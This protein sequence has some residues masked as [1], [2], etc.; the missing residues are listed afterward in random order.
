MAISRSDIFFALMGILFLLYLGMVE[1]IAVL[2]AR[3]QADPKLLLRL[4]PYVRIK[5]AALHMMLVATLVYCGVLMLP[6]W[7]GLWKGDKMEVERRM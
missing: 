6:F 7:G 1:A 4:G 2:A 5:R 3:Y